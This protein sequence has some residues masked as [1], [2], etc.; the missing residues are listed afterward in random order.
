M[1]FTCYLS[2][3]T[4]HCLYIPRPPLRRAFCLLKPPCLLHR[5]EVAEFIPYLIRDSARPI[6]APL[7]DMALRSRPLQYPSTSSGGNRRALKASHSPLRHNKCIMSTSRFSH[8]EP[9]CH[10]QRS[11]P[12]PSA[13]WGSQEK[14]QR[15][16]GR[17]SC[18]TLHVFT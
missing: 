15:H 17:A 6:M 3:V 14:R 12:L 10:L 9:R 2:L 16:S 13:P 7:S 11:P 8:D 1:F 4:D 18:F 5:R